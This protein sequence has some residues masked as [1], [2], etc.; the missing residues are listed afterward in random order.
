MYDLLEILESRQHLSSDP[1]LR[2]NSIVLDAI[3]T[4]KTAPPYAARNMAI[5]H[6]AIYNVVARI[7]P[8]NGPYLGRAMP[9]RNASAPAAVAQAAHDTLSALY[10]SLKSEF[11]SA[12]DS[13]LA[14]I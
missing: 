10:P 1:V 11:D 9:A 2:W 14:K 4:S 5:V 8:E 13:S 7:F 12:L 3:R 6:T